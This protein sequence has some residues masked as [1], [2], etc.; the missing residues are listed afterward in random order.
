MYGYVR[1]VFVVKPSRWLH[2]SRISQWSIHCS[3]LAMF[4]WI[5]PVAI[6]SRASLYDWHGIHESSTSS[7]RSETSEVNAR[8]WRLL[9]NFWQPASKSEDHRFS[10]EHRKFSPLILAAYFTRIKSTFSQSVDCHWDRRPWSSFLRKP[11]LDMPSSRQKTKTWKIVK[12]SL[13]ISLPWKMPLQ[14]A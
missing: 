2:F 4:G 14:C 11:Q 8:T 13:K 7:Q 9:V 1:S 6:V 3:F 10:L 12:L 5:L